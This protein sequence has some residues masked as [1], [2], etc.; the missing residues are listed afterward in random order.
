M[1]PNNKINNALTWSGWRDSNRDLLLPNQLLAAARQRSTGL[2][3]ASTCEDSR[4]MPLESAW[5]RCLLAPTL[6]PTNISTSA[7]M[8]TV[9]ILATCL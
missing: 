8:R 5:L 9:L 3:V 6:A 1:D 7:P 4:W 2:H